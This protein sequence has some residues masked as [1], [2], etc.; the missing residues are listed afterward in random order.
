MYP[1]LLEEDCGINSSACIIEY[2][3]SLQ[4]VKTIDIIQSICKTNYTILA[5]ANPNKNR[6]ILHYL[7][8]LSITGKINVANGLSIL[9]SELQKMHIT[10]RQSRQ[11]CLLD[12]P[13]NKTPNLCISVIK[14]FQW[15]QRTRNSFTSSSTDI[16]ALN[17]GI[18]VV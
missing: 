17:H 18:S 3:S 15:Y 6:I 4:R 16:T 10:N 12:T 13:L 11:I 7:Y 8:S 5:V 9:S 2:N 1:I 14:P